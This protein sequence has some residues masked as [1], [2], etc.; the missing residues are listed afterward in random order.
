MGRRKFNVGDRVI[1][2]DKKGSFWGRKGR[3]VG[4]IQEYSQYQV[5][6]DN[7]LTEVVYSWWIDPLNEKEV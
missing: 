2:N 6:F 4:Y 3:I 5:L 1:G 7:G